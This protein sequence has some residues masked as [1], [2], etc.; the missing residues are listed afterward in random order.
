MKWIEKMRHDLGLELYHLSDI[1]YL[2]FSF[3]QLKFS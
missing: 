1:I 2:V 3:A